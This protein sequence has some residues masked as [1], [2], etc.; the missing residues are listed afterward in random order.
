MARRNHARR[1]ERAGQK[2][3]SYSLATEE[4]LEKGNLN[5]N[6]DGPCPENR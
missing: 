2:T 4:V 1:R 6:G 3:E 5:G